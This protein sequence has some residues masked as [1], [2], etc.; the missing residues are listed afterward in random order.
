[1]VLM[2]IRNQESYLKYEQ[3]EYVS[4]LKAVAYQKEVIQHWEPASEVRPLKHANAAMAILG[5]MSSI[6]INGLFRRKLKLQSHG[7]VFTLCTMGGPGL[8]TAA[9]HEF[10]ITQPILLYERGC[11]ICYEVKA[12]FLINCTAVLFPLLLAPTIN[13]A[14]ASSIGLRIPYVNEVKELA[15][16]W[17]S[18]VK[19]ATTHLSILC[20]VNSVFASLI[21]YRELI[22]IETVAK[23][24]LDIEKEYNRGESEKLD[25]FQ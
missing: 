24:L 21:T 16:F 12:A 11:P 7:I 5:A 23:V 25:M 1:M 13:L 14:V 2:P 22:S 20:T 9:L 18:V 8:L 15:K 17:W 19:P 3:Q 10:V 4:R 6:T